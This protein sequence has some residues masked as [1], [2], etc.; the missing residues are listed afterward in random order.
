[1]KYAISD[2]H[3]N[4]DLYIKMLDKI[5]FND[6]DTLYVLGDCIDRGPKPI[7]ILLDMMERP[8]VIPIIGNHD[9]RML[10][11]LSRIKLNS[12]EEAKN[13]AKTNQ[14]IDD[15]FY[16]GG[17]VTISE[18]V[19]LD[20]ERKDKILKYLNKFKV[21]EAF[22]IG[23]N[24]FFLSH[25]APY[26]AKMNNLNKTTLLDFTWGE[27]EYNKRYFDDGYLVSG[28]TPTG[29][30]DRDYRGRIYQKNGHIAIDCGAFFTGVL[31]CVCLD[32]LEEFYVSRW[33]GCSC[34]NIVEELTGIKEI[35][36]DQ[37]LYEILGVNPERFKNLPF[38]KLELSHRAFVCLNH[39]LNHP[40]ATCEPGFVRRD[41]ISDLLNMTLIEYQNVLN[42]GKNCFVEVIDKLAYVTRF[43]G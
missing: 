18:Y 15:W 26:K 38:E 4:Y 16:D 36:G 13:Y 34:E 22:S 9:H 5:S 11:V 30:I 27:I 31:G 1:M 39:Y 7:D 24:S 41:K 40:F 17:S 32:T 25:T 6:N 37:P 35:K 12:L 3:G 8:N 42:L 21:M 19:K 2:I 29:L 23:K 33:E 10:A 20:D 43:Y 14:D 28:H